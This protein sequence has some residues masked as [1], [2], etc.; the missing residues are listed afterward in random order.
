[1]KGIEA[2]SGAYKRFMMRA[3]GE[4]RFQPIGQEEKAAFA[5]LDWMRK[6]GVL[7]LILTGTDEDK[8]KQVRDI[9]DQI[10]RSLSPL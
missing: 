7:D 3:S 4:K 1:M 5:A 8:E 2:V 9:V 6:R 10:G